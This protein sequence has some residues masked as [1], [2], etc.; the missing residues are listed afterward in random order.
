[1]FTFIYIRSII[2]VLCK[3]PVHTAGDKVRLL[4]FGGFSIVM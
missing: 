3:T 1:M 4:S 2:S